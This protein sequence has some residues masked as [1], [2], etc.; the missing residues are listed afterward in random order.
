MNRKTGTDAGNRKDE[1]KER[2]KVKRWAGAERPLLHGCISVNACTAADHK[3]E[4][5]AKECENRVPSA[6]HARTRGHKSLRAP[7]KKRI[8]DPS[9]AMHVRVPVRHAPVS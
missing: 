5:T 4:K 8:V 7:H 2:R 9:I 3:E 1:K 6:Q